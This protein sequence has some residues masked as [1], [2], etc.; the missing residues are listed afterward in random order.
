MKN[1]TFTGITV[2]RGRFPFRLTFSHHLATRTEAETLLVRVAAGEGSPGYG[3]AL[4][5]TYLTGESMDD[6][7]KSIRDR[8]WP[9]FRERGL[10]DAAAPPPSLADI[11][12]RHADLHAAADAVRENASYAAVDIAATAAVLRSRSVTVPEWSG[13]KPLVGVIT[14]GGARK[15]Y[16]LARALYWLGYRW[17][18][19]KVGRDEDA[20]RRRL[21]AVKK[22]VGNG[23]RLF[24]D[25]NASWDVGT[26]ER[27][28]AELARFGSDVVEEPCAAG[29]AAAAD[30]RRLERSTGVK[31][32]ADES[33][34]T[35]ADARRLAAAGGPSYWNVRL[36]K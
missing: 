19:V 24:A 26:A 1:A 2:W 6:A 25:A 16:W 22:A 10:P 11:V 4:P 28:L 17:F 31:L 18:K 27:R 32:M 34:V 9:A 5:R 12:A 14:G 7:E 35:R 15:A 36:A 29:A 21:R 3:Q 13:R 30:W 23:C 8:W 33:L 20:D